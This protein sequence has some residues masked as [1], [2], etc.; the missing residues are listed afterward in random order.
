[1]AMRRQQSRLKVREKRKKR[2]ERTENFMRRLRGKFR[3]FHVRRQRDVVFVVV[4]FVVVVPDLTTHKAFRARR[5]GQ[6]RRAK[7]KSQSIRLVVH[8]LS[9]RRHIAS[10]SLS[11]SLSLQPARP[12]SSSFSCFL[13]IL[14]PSSLP[15]PPFTLRHPL[16]FILV[17]SSPPRKSSP[18]SAP[19]SSSSY[20]FPSSPCVR[21]F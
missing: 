7:S 16:S 15:R 20:S 2:N 17:S 9:M 4:L 8:A 6:G 13:H 11:L 3:R 10:S 19:A 1:M 12:L 5:F 18:A 21:F 14:P